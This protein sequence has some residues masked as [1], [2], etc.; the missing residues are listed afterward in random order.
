MELVLLQLLVMLLFFC[1]ALAATLI[2]VFISHRQKYQNLTNTKC[3]AALNAGNS[4]AGRFYYVG[5]YF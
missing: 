3:Q 2:P 1:I 5:S 4:I